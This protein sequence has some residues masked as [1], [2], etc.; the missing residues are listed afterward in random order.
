MPRSVRS[1]NLDSRAA[2]LRL[3]PRKKPYWTPTGKAGVHLGYRRRKPR[4]GAANG[5][6]LVRRYTGKGYETEVFAEADDYSDADNAGVLNYYEAIKRLG[7]ELSEIQRSRQYTVSQ[8]VDDYLAWARLHTRSARDA[9][10]K[11]RAYLLPFFDGREV[12]SLRPVDFDRWLTWAEKQR[13]MGRRKKAGRGSSVNTDPADLKRRRKATLNRIINVVKACLN[14]AYRDGR[15]TSDEGWRNLRRFKGADSARAQW[16]TV[17]E[18]GRLL[19]ACQ[20]DFRRV[21]ETALLTGARWGELRALRVGDYDSRSGY[22]LIAESKGGKPRR[23]PLTD[24]GRAAL[25]TMTAGRDPT[26]LLL[27][28]ADG[29]PWGMQ[30]QKRPMSEACAAAKIKPPIGFHALR[31]T[32]ASLLVQNGTPLAIVAEALG[33]SDTRMVDRHYAHLAP[34]HVA[35]AIRANLPTIG[36]QLESKVRRLRK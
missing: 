20:T 28:R 27:T 22:L 11:L 8:A 19:N 32:Y 3:E 9:E 34:S 17:A 13:P 1:R 5:S 6:W 24:E 23:I 35:D 16:L 30:D 12:A 26:D 18:C 25:D 21:V 31:H 10:W 33:H 7:G 2:R 14:K 15:V 29:Q 36:A 4:T